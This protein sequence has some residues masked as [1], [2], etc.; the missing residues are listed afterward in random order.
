MTF[1]FATPAGWSI[2]INQMAIARTSHFDHLGDDRAA[3][4]PQSARRPALSR[5]FLIGGDR[6]LMRLG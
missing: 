6:G 3:R 2:R 5:L 4:A 1:W